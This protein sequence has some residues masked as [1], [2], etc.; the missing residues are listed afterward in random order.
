[1]PGEEASAVE[2]ELADGEVHRE[3]R[4]RP[5]AGPDLAA[6]ADDLRLP[7]AQVVCDVAV[8]PAAVRLGHEHVDVL[9]QDLGG[10]IAEDLLRG[11]V[12]RLGPSPARRW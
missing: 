9:A 10:R 4:S 5:C 2:P 11:R 6:D 7:G 8:V 3:R 12:E 1:M